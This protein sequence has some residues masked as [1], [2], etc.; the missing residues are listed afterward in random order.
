MV[1]NDAA[2]VQNES[3]TQHEAEECRRAIYFHH[4]GA[5]RSVVIWFCCWQQWLWQ[6]QALD[7]GQF[8]FPWSETT[9]PDS[10]LLDMH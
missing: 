2:E 5:L 6:E 4:S 8:V 9:Q 7:E 1:D 3:N 10:Q